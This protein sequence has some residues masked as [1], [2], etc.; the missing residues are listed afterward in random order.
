MSTCS[1]CGYPI[2]PDAPRNYLGTHQ[3]HMYRNQCI[4]LL[5]ANIELLAA[6]LETNEK[7]LKRCREVLNTPEMESFDA[8]VPLEAA[9][10]Q[11]RWGVEH[12]AGKKPEDWFWLI[13]YLAG[14]ALRAHLTGDAGKAKHHCVST[15]AVLRN[16][17]AHIRSGSTLM[18]PG[19]AGPCVESADVQSPEN[20]D[21]N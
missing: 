3:Q 17:H 5:R 14:K 12:D 20:T 16:W 11:L 18:R 1:A 9:H 8:G 4:Q 21:R 15:A 2:H 6:E 13:G 10:Q 7:E 19:I